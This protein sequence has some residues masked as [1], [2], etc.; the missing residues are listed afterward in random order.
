MQIIQAH[1]HY[2]GCRQSRQRLNVIC[3]IYGRIVNIF[4]DDSDPSHHWMMIII[5]ERQ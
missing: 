3:G 1:N 4:D 2:D 5:N